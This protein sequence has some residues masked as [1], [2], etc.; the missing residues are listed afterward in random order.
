M[1]RSMMEMT[2]VLNRE[3]DELVKYYMISGEF[4]SEFYKQYDA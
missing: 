3:F 2:D 1:N 4:D